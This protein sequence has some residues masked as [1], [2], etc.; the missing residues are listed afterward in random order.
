MGMAF[1]KS[2]RDPLRWQTGIQMIYVDYLRR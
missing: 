1:E 2:M